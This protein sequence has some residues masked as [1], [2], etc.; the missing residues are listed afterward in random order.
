MSGEDGAWT[1]D[2]FG[3]GLCHGNTHCAERG[4][5]KKS[6]RVGTTGVVGMSCTLGDVTGDAGSESVSGG[7]LGGAVG[8]T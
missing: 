6:K 7:T 8:V 5:S 3:R 4:S 2:G 1:S